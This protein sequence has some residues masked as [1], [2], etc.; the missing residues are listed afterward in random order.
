MGKNIVLCSDGTGNQDIKNRGTNVFKLYEAVDIQ[1]HKNGALPK[2]VAFYDDGVGTANPIAKVIGG[3]FGWGFSAN[4]KMLYRELVNVYEAGDSLYLF[5]FSRGAYTVR[6]LAGLI[7]FCG[8]LDIEHY[9]KLG[10]DALSDQI[11]ACWE[12][13][14]RVAFKMSSAAERRSAVPS[15]DE[16]NIVTGRREGYHAVDPGGELDIPF[17]GVWD[18]VGAIGVPFDEL[19]KFISLFYPV[20]FA[21]NTL[22][23]EVKRACQALAIDDERRTF[24]PE[25]WNEQNG[26]DT[27]ILQVWFSGVHSNVGGGYPKQGMSLVTL[28]WMMAEARQA[29]LRFIDEDLEFVHEHQDV[30]DK[31]YDSRSGLAVYYRWAPRDI[32]KLC[33][34][35][36]IHRPKVHVSVFERIGNGTDAYA[37][38]N[39]PFDCEVDTAGSFGRWPDAKAAQDIR[40]ALIARKAGHGA[41]LLEDM[42]ATVEKGKRSYIAFLI[43]TLVTLS[44]F[45]GLARCWSWFNLLWPATFFLVCG[46]LIF[47]WARSVDNALN[48][49]YAQFWHN[50][51]GLLRKML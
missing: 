8:V 12:D 31:L 46:S 49:E 38:G 28:D 41:S 11:D 27:R 6:A 50:L 24:H 7:Q 19:R 36:R 20:W 34:E 35:H 44:A 13:F 22:G 42:D 21:D 48:R 47:L 51:R 25:L 23:G 16:K 39:I 4:V 5:G 29:G 17:I 45:S 40:S 26:S 3:A 18:T 10:R 2:Q 37:P 15:A 33:A 32:A 1:G 14:R 30:H 9:N 43:M